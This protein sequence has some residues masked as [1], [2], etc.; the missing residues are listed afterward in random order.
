MK[1][2]VNFLLL[3]TALILS[4]NFYPV[5]ILFTLIAATTQGS[6]EHAVLYISNVALSITCSLDMMGNVICGDLLNNIM[7]KP[8]GY[9]FGNYKE[10][11]S[12]CLGKNKA[13]GTLST[14]D[15]ILADILNMIQ[16]NHV[17]LAAQD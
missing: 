5:G 7:R 16:K 14:L 11:I 4:I 17:E 3:L 9:P 8:G 13:L 12:R 6:F 10:T 1:I 15:L 2:A